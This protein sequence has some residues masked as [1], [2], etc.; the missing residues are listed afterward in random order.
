[1]IQVNDKQYCCGCSA[2]EQ[3]CP[4]QCI[5]MH[6]DKMGFEYPLVEQER[7]INCS[8]CEKVC[9]Y[10]QL[11][12]KREP[13]Q[14]F[15]AKA[16]DNTIRNQSSSGGLFT[17]IAEQTIK[18][19]GVVFGAK[20]DSNWDIV[21]S[22]TEAI[23]GLA[24]FRGS[25]YVQSKIGESYQQVR[26]FLK[27]GRKVLFT[28]TPCQ[29]A[30][31][32]LFLN[33]EYA[34]LLLVDVACHGVPSPEVWQDYLTSLSD[35][36]PTLVKFRSKSRGWSK[37]SYVVMHRNLTTVDQPHDDNVY[38]LAFLNDLTLRPSCFNCPSKAG[39]S[40]S[41]ITIADCW[42]IDALLPNVND[43]KGHNLVLVNS[44]K[45]QR[46]IEN[47]TLEKQAVNFHE[48]VKYNPALLYSTSK[49]EQYDRFWSEYINRGFET[50]FTFLPPKRQ[51]KEISLY[52]RL[53]YRLSLLFHDLLQ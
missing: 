7:C 33:K 2:C 21:H 28:G 19:G 45:G 23:D 47:L 12:D 4:R 39:R 1:M 26:S 8:L 25:K 53:K 18:N 38:S 44:L 36:R 5:T 41:D 52:K 42:G 51:N 35:E 40:G 31:L 13:L 15:A 14:T 16:L 17:L 30:G 34:N 20:F 49:T 32:R 48:S 11:T 46:I 37:Y 29:V 6:R 43:D 9:V 24:E 3:I 27:S 22:Y 10:T 50:I